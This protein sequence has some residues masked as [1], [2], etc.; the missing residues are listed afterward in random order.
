[1]IYWRLLSEIRSGQIWRLVT[2]IFIHFGPLHL[3]FNMMTL[4]LLGGQVES[5][6]GSIRMGLLV[7][8]LA[9]ASNLA[10]Y[11][12]GHPSIAN[13]WI[14]FQS[15]PQFGGMSGVLFGLFGYAWMKSRFEPRLGLNLPRETVY[16]ML[17]WFFLC[18]LGVIPGI[19]NGAHAG[20]LLLG[21]LIGYAPTFWHWL[22]GGGQV[23][24]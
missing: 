12:L 22:R 24:V 17:V 9:V 6:R 2:P 13:G 15:S 10:E 21:L 16:L 8:I 19:A 11:Y 18:L 1:M 23:D 20:G 3:V 14:L 7:L 5:R 4:L